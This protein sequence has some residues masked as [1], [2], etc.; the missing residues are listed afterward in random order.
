RVSRGLGYVYKR[1]IMEG[2]VVL[3]KK[4]NILI[5]ILISSTILS[6]LFSIVMLTLTVKHDKK[7]TGGSLG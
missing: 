5:A 2:V 3:N 4:L 6:S 7:V 1:Q